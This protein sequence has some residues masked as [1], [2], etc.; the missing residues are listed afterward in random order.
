MVGP[1]QRQSVLCVAVRVTVDA[2][3]QVVQPLGE[4]LAEGTAVDEDDRRLVVP[5]RLKDA[6]VDRGPQ[7]GRL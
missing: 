2:D 5:H 3:R 7:T 4:P 1:D 6:R